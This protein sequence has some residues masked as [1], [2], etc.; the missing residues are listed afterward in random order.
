MQIKSKMKTLFIFLFFCLFLITQL[1]ANADEFNITAKEILVDKEKQ[2]LFG[3]GSVEATD[4]KGMIINADKITYEKSREFVLAEG[5]V[6]IINT[7][8]SIIL[9]SKASYDKPNEIMVAYNN[10][11]LLLQEG[12]ELATD[13][14]TYNTLNKL[15]SSNKKSVLNNFSMLLSF[16]HL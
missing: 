14:L 15:V 11:R 3:I 16:L 12:Y 7:D 13:S 2:I 9:S 6:K 8:G 10:T 4:S 5:N 1:N